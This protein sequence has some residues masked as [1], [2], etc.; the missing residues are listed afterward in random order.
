MHQ[1]LKSIHSFRPGDAWAVNQIIRTVHTTTVFLSKPCCCDANKQHPPIKGEHCAGG[2]PLLCFWETR[3]SFCARLLCGRN[4]ATVTA[5]TLQ[6]LRMNMVTYD[7]RLLALLFP[8]WR[9]GKGPYYDVW[10]DALFL[11]SKWVK[12]ITEWSIPSI[13]KLL[14]NT[15]L[16][17]CMP[18]NFQ[19]LPPV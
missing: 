17:D 3:C 1:R 6:S 5:A 2:R 15:K 18:D 7:F 19:Y 10:S 13:R 4:Y 14:K 16:G 11:E 9:I 12:N 8:L